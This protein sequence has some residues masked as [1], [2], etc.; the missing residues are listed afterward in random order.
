MK[1]G[2]LVRVTD[3]FNKDIIHCVGIFLKTEPGSPGSYQTWYTIFSDQQ[4][5]LYDDS[6]CSFDVLSSTR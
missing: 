6:Y 4:S 5:L 2:D 1:P 3:R